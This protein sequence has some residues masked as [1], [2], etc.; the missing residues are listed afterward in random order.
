MD[1]ILLIACLAFQI[2]TS[3][4]VPTITPTPGYCEFT[5]TPQSGTDPFDV[6]DIIDLSTP[7]PGSAM[8]TATY[9]ALPTQQPAVPTVSP[10][11]WRWVS[12]GSLAT[13]NGSN[14]DTVQSV[15][16]PDVCYGGEVKGYH[17]Q[18]T[19][20]Q[21]GQNAGYHYTLQGFA[22]KDFKNTTTNSLV[23]NQE[24]W[25][26]QSSNAETV[27][28][29]I[30][31]IA[32]A[33]RPNINQDLHAPLTFTVEIG[34][35]SSSYPYSYLQVNTFE[36]LCSGGHN[37]DPN[38][39]TP[40]QNP[41]TPTPCVPFESIEPGDPISEFD[42]DLIGT[43]CFTILQTVYYDFSTLPDW[44]TSVIDD[45]I[46]PMPI[47]DV[48][49][50][51]VCLNKWHLTATILNIDMMAPITA[52]MALVCVGLIIGEFRS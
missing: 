9:S 38:I 20:I 16:I 29:G 31:N 8:L 11:T 26:V 49:G 24:F 6:I 1:T 46:N 50:V 34:A 19:H 35:G 51:T 36:L 40:I 21:N 7:T 23:R 37:S 12:V 25:I 33:S 44:L 22:T 13:F 30:P 2:S 47:I 42:N 10:N 28:S 17:I 3:T 43:E 52:L 45:V 32:S 39:G 15:S 14:V 27:P 5:S 18:H 4:P 48:P 41:L